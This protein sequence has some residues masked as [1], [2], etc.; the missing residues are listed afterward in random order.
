MPDAISPPLSTALTAPT[1]AISLPGKPV[2]GD[3]DALITANRPAAKPEPKVPLTVAAL[4]ADPS[5][6]ADLAP[7]TADPPVASPPPPSPELARPAP[8]QAHAA[9]GKTLPPARP[10]TR[11]GAPVTDEGDEP[12]ATDD[13]AESGYTPAAALPPSPLP[14]P[15]PTPDPRREVAATIPAATSGTDEVAALTMHRGA[16]ADAPDPAPPFLA[17]PTLA[18]LPVAPSTLAP[19]VA[20]ALDPSLSEPVPLPSLAT[21]APVHAG[22]LPLAET[23]G[24]DH[25][26]STATGPA[27]VRDTAVPSGQNNAPAGALLVDSVAPAIRGPMPLAPAQAVVAPPTG[28][29]ISV[30]TGAPAS[31]TTSSVVAPTRTRSPTA[32]NPRVPRARTLSPETP[33]SRPTSAEATDRLLRAR[34]NTA[35]ALGPVTATADASLA[36]AQ[37]VP[38]HP[39]APAQAAASAPSPI[40]TETR[41]WRTQMLDRIEHFAAAAP[42]H[43]RETHIRLSPDALGEVAVRL[44][45]TD[46]GIE[47]VVDAAPEARALLAEAAPRL[48]ELAESRGLRLT[49]SQP[50][51][52]EGSGDRPQPQQPRQ[53]TDAPIPNRRAAHRGAADTPTDERIA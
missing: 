7:A 26:A 25:E 30:A 18:P 17:Q 1:S 44:K 10:A 24:E 35:F 22:R 19:N 47:V 36:A 32:A 34:P 52:G 9:T 2:A 38:T 12:A 4:V 51:A 23:L 16:C 53:Q 14:P 33:I 28:I 45:E 15:V 11:A 40:D 37:T 20:Q 41:E 29:P 31:P 8:R 6:T 5:S 3:F 42:A 50:G 39:A 13:T 48:T 27:A 21:A 43:G 49:M 46:R